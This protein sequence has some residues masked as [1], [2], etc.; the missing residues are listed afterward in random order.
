[1]KKFN[2]N[3]WNYRLAEQ[4]WE[5]LCETEDVDIMATTLSKNVN[6]ALDICA[7]V[8]TFKIRPAFIPGLKPDTK[9]LWKK[10]T[11]QEEK[12]NQRLVRNI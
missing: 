9:S 4:N 7:P 3:I 5:A 10:E 12:L 2:I 1:M 6:A 11:G 8:K